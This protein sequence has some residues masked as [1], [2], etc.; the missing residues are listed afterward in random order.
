MILEAERHPENLIDAGRWGDA[1]T[2]EFWRS[3]EMPPVEIC[4][5]IALVAIMDLERS[6]TVL[7][8]NDRGW[9]MIAGGIDL[10]ESPEDALRR[11]ALEEG[12]FVVVREQIYGYRKIIN[13]GPPDPAAKRNYPPLAY[14]PYYFAYT[15]SPLLVPTGEEITDSGVFSIEDRETQALLRPGELLLIREG[16]RA[17]REARR[18]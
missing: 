3:S 4:S 18:K 6:D 5:A 7:T 16:L 9:E 12:G 2:W 13:E 1:T 17:A 8:E 10:G 14:M 15:N 11:E